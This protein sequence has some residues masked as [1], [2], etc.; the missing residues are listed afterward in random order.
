MFNIIEPRTHHLHR[1]KIETILK[2]FKS[3]QGFELSMKAQSKATFIIAE[4]EARGLYGGAVFFPQK[5]R[6]LDK[7]ISDLLPILENQQFGVH[8]FICA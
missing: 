6:D 8:V 5:V 7:N 1:D 2:R 4:N 3:Q